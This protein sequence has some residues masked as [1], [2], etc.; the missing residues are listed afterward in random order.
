MLLE[1]LANS[2][3]ENVLTGRGVIKLS[4]GVTRTDQNFASPF[5]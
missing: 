2:I 3:L 5:K 1:T 4:G